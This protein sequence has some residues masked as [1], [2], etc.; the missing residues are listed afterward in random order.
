[1]YGFT[2]VIL[3]YYGPHLHIAFSPFKMISV[4]FF[5]VFVDFAKPSLIITEAETTKHGPVFTISLYPSLKY[6]V[7][8]WILSYRLHFL[9]SIIVR[10][11]NTTERRLMRW[12][13]KRCVQS[14][15]CLL[16]DEVSSLSYRQM[17]PCSGLC[18]YVVT[19]DKSNKQ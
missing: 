14:P 6:L 2:L 10:F 18:T 9:A 4:L 15:G 1:M 3:L 11:G 7:N 8:I 13:K 12:M 16:Y 19:N 17:C 5:P